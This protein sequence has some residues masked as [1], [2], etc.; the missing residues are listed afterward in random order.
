MK[1]QGDDHRA[2]WSSEA[3]VRWLQVT[4]PLTALTLLVAGI[5]YRY[6]RKRQ[7]LKQHTKHTEQL[8]DPEK[9]MGKES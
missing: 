5:G 2:S 9:A 3:M 1:Y 6:E 7:I 8:N 4:I